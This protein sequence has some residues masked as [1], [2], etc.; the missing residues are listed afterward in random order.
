MTLVEV[1][2]NN[3]K[4]RRKS[5]SPEAKERLR[6]LYLNRPLSEETKYKMSLVRKGRTA[7]NKGIRL[8]DTAKE[9]ISN[10]MKEWWR[11]RHKQNNFLE[12]EHT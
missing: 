7:P 10:G 1:G 9:N 3:H 6:Q 8:S 12:K 2:K 11:Q 5:M 4:R